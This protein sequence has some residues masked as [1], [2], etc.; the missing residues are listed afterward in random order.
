MCAALSLA[1]ASDML[2]LR[3]DAFKDFAEVLLLKVVERSR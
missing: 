2:S 1:E 3:A